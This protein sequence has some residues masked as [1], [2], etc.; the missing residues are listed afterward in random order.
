[1]SYKPCSFGGRLV[2]LKSVPKQLLIQGDIFDSLKKV[3]A[4]E[5]LHAK[6]IKFRARKQLVCRNKTCFISIFSWEQM[7]LE[8]LG[9]KSP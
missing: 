3:Y 1:M 4:C 6:G 2:F 7:D 5:R 8:I 9:S